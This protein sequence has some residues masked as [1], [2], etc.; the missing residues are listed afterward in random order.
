MY[1][2]DDEMNTEMNATPGATF[3]GEDSLPVTESS[4]PRGLHTPGPW[5]VDQLC[6]E[7]VTHGNICLVN[8][9]RSSKADLN[10]IAAA[11]DLLELA[12]QF[13]NDCPRCL[14][15]G[16]FEADGDFSRVATEEC[17]KCADIRAVIA[18]A[19]GRS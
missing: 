7:S 12:K 19:E 4:R 15:I 17:T 3:A 8:L 13:A 16:R 14:G 9:A 5:R 2:N 11:P 1:Q 18:K 10:L 6:V